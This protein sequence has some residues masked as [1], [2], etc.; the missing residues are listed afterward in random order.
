[1]T[2]RVATREKLWTG[3][4]GRVVAGI[5]SLAFLVGFEAL[6]VAT[7]MPIVARDLHG[8]SL[9]ALSF[10]A[11]TVVAVV[12]MTVAGSHTDRH[13]PRLALRAGVTVFVFGLVAAGL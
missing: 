1:M 5:F 13:G 2:E 12:S 3:P 7:V 6:A 4:H 11:P 9:Y 10:A 8:I